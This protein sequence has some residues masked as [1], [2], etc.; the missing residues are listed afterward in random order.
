[1]MILLCYVKIA[2]NKLGICGSHRSG[3]TTLATKIAEQMGIPFVKT[4]TSQV[5]KD[6]GLDPSQPMNFAVRLD[7]QTRIVASA[8]KVWE[9]GGKNFITDRTPIDMMAYTLADIKGDIQVNFSAL[10][11]YLKRCFKAVN[12]FF[13]NMFIIQP[14][15]PLVYTRGKAALNRSYIEHL[16]SLII[17]LA[18]DERI[19]TGIRAQTIILKRSDTCLQDRI[20]IIIDSARYS[21]NESRRYST[22]LPEVVLT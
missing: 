6:N 14:G 16:N 1:M 4:Y 13:T 2:M 9:K 12:Y 3:K 22:G 19:N 8:E 10:E 5:F 20:R 21:G 17:G 11:A 7:I 15:I 18:L